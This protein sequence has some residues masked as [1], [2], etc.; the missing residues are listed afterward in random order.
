MGIRNIK[1]SMPQ[2]KD[3]S[4]IQQDNNRTPSG[5]KVFF[6]CSITRLCIHAYL[7]PLSST[8]YAQPK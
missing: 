2:K 5:I 3:T 7:T 4:K 8:P 6:I 1:R